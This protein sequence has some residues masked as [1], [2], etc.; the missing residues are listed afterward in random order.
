[1]GWGLAG[2]DRCIQLFHDIAMYKTV[3]LRFLQLLRSLTELGFLLPPSSSLELVTALGVG[4]GAG[5]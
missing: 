4:V 2:G 3:V 1:M 5:Q